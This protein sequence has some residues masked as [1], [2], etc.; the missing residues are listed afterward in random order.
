MIHKLSRNRSIAFLLIFSLF[1]TL[2]TPMTANAGVLGSLLSF[3]KPHANI[4][5]KIGGAIAGASLGS[6]FCPPLGT[7]AGGIIGYVV[8]GTIAD[9]AAGGLSNCATLAGAAAGYVAMSSMGPVGMIAGVFLGGLVGKVAYSLIKKIDNKVTG[10]IVFAPEVSEESAKIG[11]TS[12]TRVVVTDNTIPATYDGNNKASQ[13]T[14]ASNTNISVQEAQEKYQAA[15]QNYATAVRD[16]AN[17]TEI[18]KAYK[19]YQ[20][21]YETYRKVTGK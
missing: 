17:S 21:A 7:I 14:S 1:F 4:L 15:Y 13:P 8:G 6:A 12:N 16:G 11:D 2:F 10:G 18:N 9:Y 3:I 19:E 20:E 5:G